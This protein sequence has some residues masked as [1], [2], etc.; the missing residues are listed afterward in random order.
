MQLLRSFHLIV[1]QE[2]TCHA[3]IVYA[4]TKFP[5]DN[6]EL[7]SVDCVEYIDGLDNKSSYNGF[8]I[9]LEIDVRWTLDTVH[10]DTKDDPF[11]ARV[12]SRNT[13]LL[14]MPG[15][16]YVTRYDRDKSPFHDDPW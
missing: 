7:H 9:W 10:D 13:V 8:D 14:T 12:F 1:T 2:N 4:N 3:G 16:P 5:E 6:R 15:V 11:C